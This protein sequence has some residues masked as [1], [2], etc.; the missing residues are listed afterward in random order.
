M[1][2]VN[3][4]LF[5]CVNQN[6]NT[7]KIIESLLCNSCKQQLLWQFL[8]VE[9]ALRILRQFLVGI[10]IFISVLFPIQVLDR[11]PGNLWKIL[12][13]KIQIDQ[14]SCLS[15]LVVFIIRNMISDLCI[16]RFK[17]SGHYNI[18]TSKNWDFT[19]F[20]EFEDVVAKKRFIS[21]VYEIKYIL[22]SCILENW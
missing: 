12:R 3:C 2:L 14:S 17:F 22:S 19:R 10:H 9:V 4:L 16:A 6:G 20:N 18:H 11:N 21:G 5:R 1:S 8:T 7:I 13:H 15:V